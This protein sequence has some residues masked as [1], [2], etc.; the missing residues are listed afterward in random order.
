VKEEVDDLLEKA[1][2]L[3][4][5][6]M[7]AEAL[8]VLWQA[9]RHGDDP[10]VLTRIGALAT[11]LEFWLEA[12]QA[13]QKAI[14]LESSFTLALFYLG[15]L[16][17][18]QGRFAEALRCLSKAGTDE[19]SADTLNVLGVIQLQLDLM[20]QAQFSFRKAISLDPQHE[21][22]HYNLATTLRNR[23]KD[24]AIW[25]LGKAI[26]IDP[27]YA[28]AHREMGFLLRISERFL[29]AEY[30]LQRA[31]ELAPSDGW[32]YI[33]LG[34]LLWATERFREAE[35]AFRKAIEVWPEQSISHWALAHYLE[36]TGRSLEARQLYQKA[37]ELDPSDLQANWRFA[38]YLKDTGEYEQA[39]LYFGRLLELDP[40]DERAAS[41]LAA[42]SR[43]HTEND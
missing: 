2:E 27:N 12:E 36:V 6:G 3:E 28:L 20:D 18:E 7:K 8:E 39:K 29:E 15:L 4:S 10:I 42:L 33:Y 17:K 38:N 26:D 37:I 40:N 1:D 43:R 19:P 22:A 30:H 9:A 24:E 34:N 11:D 31:I 35:N 23:N 13:L 21:E 16:Y 5:Q 14:R 25:L 41:A 32:T